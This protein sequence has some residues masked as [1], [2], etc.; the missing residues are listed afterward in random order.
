M[1][2]LEEIR[3]FYP[4]NLH[5]FPGFMIR[6]Y[7]QYKILDF[8]YKS[9]FANSLSF[10]G[11]T[12]LRIIHGNHRFSED[13]DFDNLGIKGED[14]EKLTRH[15]T[16]QL[17]RE[18]YEVEIKTVMRGA[19]HC[20]IR[21]PRLLFDGGLSG[22]KNEKILIQLDTEPQDYVYSPKRIILNKF[23]VFSAV[24]CTPLSLLLAQ[25]YLAILNRPRKKG[26]DFYDV[27]FLNSKNI[28]P[29]YQYLKNKAEIEE[30]RMLKDALENVCKDL[31]M[32][33]IAKDVEP[34][35]FDPGDQD[36]I[37]FFYEYLQ[38]IFSE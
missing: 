2:K 24:L 26:R 6:E 4:E 1:L 13:L 16:T 31:D 30:P 17:E 11:G 15:I 12:C 7:L 14:F 29:D 33:L 10:M 23:E 22:Y 27:L 21:F 36:R 20:Y 38:S 19:W 35:L 37:L 25:K 9:D 28:S 32:N 8:I 5:K 18:G 34:F 3:T